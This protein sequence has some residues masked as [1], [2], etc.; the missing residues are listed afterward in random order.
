MLD[1]FL[2]LH[3]QNR[4][5]F[6][7]DKFG[8]ESSCFF[9]NILHPIRWFLATFLRENI[10][11]LEC[12]TQQALND[13]NQKQHIAGS[14]AF[15]H[16]APQ[17]DTARHTLA[18]LNPLLGSGP[19]RPSDNDVDHGESNDGLTSL[20]NRDSEI[21]VTVGMEQ[22]MVLA[23]DPFI[24]APHM[25]LQIDSQIENGAHLRAKSVIFARLFLLPP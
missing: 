12:I 2:L 19:S 17:F 6:G 7:C 21:L 10:Y 16:S 22:L 25:V 14:R 4:A 15:I 9:F 3:I 23:R 1:L 5:S 24:V 20:F 18:A 11:D 8:V 13:V